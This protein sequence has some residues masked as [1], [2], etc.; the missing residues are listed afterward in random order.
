MR[1]SSSSEFT[2]RQVDPACPEVRAILLRHLEFCVS[3]T[4]P[5]KVHALGPAALKAPGIAVFGAYVNGTLV[6]IAALRR[7][8][9]DQV[10]LKSMHTISPH[11]CRGVGAALLTYLLG[12]AAGRGYRR[13]SLETGTYEAFQPARRLYE[14]FGFRECAPFGEHAPNRESVCLTREIRSAVAARPGKTPGRRA[15]ASPRSPGCGR[16][17]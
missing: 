15:A 3:V 6:G 4:P 7:L 11:R 9:A 14:K 16:Q 12:Q 10:E 8:A 17:R 13:I 2:F 5:G 1:R